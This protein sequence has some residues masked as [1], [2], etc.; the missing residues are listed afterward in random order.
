MTVYRIAPRTAYVAQDSAAE[1]TI[2][3]ASLPDGVPVVL[4]GS[5][6]LIWSALAQVQPG[7]GEGV[8]LAVSEDAGLDVAD[9][10]DD[11]VSFLS[12]LA[13]AGLLEVDA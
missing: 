1:P 5:S 10:R 8:A 13:E 6:A 4:A 9:V 3:A 11:V 7:T 2:Y 12:E